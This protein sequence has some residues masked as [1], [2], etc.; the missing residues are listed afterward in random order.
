MS[1]DNCGLK[2]ALVGFPDEMPICGK[3]CYVTCVEQL[4]ALT[5]NQGIGISQ[6]KQMLTFSQ[7]QL[8]SAK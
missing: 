2:G 4:K 1:L 7:A 8:M 5:M 3:N 6:N